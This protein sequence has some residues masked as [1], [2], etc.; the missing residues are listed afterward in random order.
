MRD[1]LPSVQKAKPRAGCVPLT[2]ESNFQISL[3]VA[4]SS[5]TIFCDGV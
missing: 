1:L 2:P 3:P 5:A 4:A